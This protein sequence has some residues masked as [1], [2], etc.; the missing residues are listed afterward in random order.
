MS[1]STVADGAAPI[2]LVTGASQRL[3]AQLA[4]FLH[5]RGMRV[6]SIITIRQPP[7]ASCARGWKRCE[8]IPRC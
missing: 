3:G 5:A 4:T 6:A 2:A 7:H 1:S 8:R